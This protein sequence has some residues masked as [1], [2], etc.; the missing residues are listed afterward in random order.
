MW[1]LWLVLEWWWWW[2]N[3]IMIM[4]S[5]ALSFTKLIFIFRNLCWL[6]DL[7]WRSS[8]TWIFTHDYSLES[9]GCLLSNHRSFVNFW[10]R[11][12][13]LWAKQWGW[14]RTYP[15]TV[16]HGTLIING[17]LRSLQ[18]F[19]KYSWIY[20]KMLVIISN[21]NFFNLYQDEYLVNILFLLLR[22]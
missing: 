3:F 1:L 15:E 18:I 20:L 4:T 12:K 6:G 9:S 5:L 11:M 19:W 8:R 13:Q 22:S 10:C 21:W 14:L 16:W 17:H 2:P 7:I